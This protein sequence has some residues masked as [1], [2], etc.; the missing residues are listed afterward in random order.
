M[1]YS[2][3]HSEPRPLADIAPE[4]PEPLAT[5][6]MRALEREPGERQGSADELGGQ[7]AAAATDAWGP[8]WHRGTT[9]AERECSRGPLAEG[10]RPLEE[11]VDGPARTLARAGER[12]REQRRAARARASRGRR[13]RS[14]TGPDRRGRACSI[15]GALV[16]L[17]GI[18]AVALLLGGGDDPDVEQARDTPPTPE[19]GAGLGVASLPPSPRPRQQAPGA[20]V[21][22]K[23]WV[24]G[25]LNGGTRRQSDGPALGHR[26]RP[27]DPAV[28][29]G[30]TRPAGGAPPRHGRDVQGRG[31]GDGRMDPARQRPRR[32]LVE[33]RLRAC[34]VSAGSS[35]R[36]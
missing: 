34:A 25:G 15:A 23:A 1:L 19:H 29:H 32:D 21:G 35:C 14:R 4:V 3:I 2:R 18:A 36:R 13:S 33:S 10:S 16:L 11:T 20:V 8:D 28:E 9:L 26:A 27:D 24:I 22:G 7:I 5:V 12:A 31:R 17:A 6:V 30:R